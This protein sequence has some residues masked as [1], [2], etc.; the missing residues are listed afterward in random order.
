VSVAEP[1]ANAAPTHIATCYRPETRG[2][3]TRV[4]ASP[5]APGAGIMMRPECWPGSAHRAQCRPVT[6]RPASN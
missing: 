5:G 2:F 1:A 4:C 6:S 3:G